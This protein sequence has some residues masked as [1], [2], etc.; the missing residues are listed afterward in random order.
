MEKQKLRSEIDEKYK[1][2]LTLI[3]KNDEDFLEDL[4]TLKT[5]MQEVD[6][7][8]DCLMKN[9][10]NLYECLNLTNELE[11]KL[12]KVYSYAH[13]H[14][15]EDTT[16]SKYQKYNGLVS[17][18]LSEYSKISG[19]IMP[20]ILKE[21]YKLLEKYYEDLP[22]LKQEYEFLLENIF[23]NKKYVLD[24][25]VEVALSKLSKAF[26]NSEEIYELLTDSDF[27]FD[28]IVDRNNKEVEI[29]NS[30]YSKYIESIDRNERKKAF[31]NLYKTYKEHINSLSK[32]LSNTVESNISISDLRGYD[33]ALSEALHSDNIDVKI[34]DNLIETVSK[35]LEPLFD[36]Y[37]HKKKLL[38]LNDFHIYDIYAPVISFL[39]K[40]YTFEEAKK[41]VIEA[42]K[43]LGEEYIEILNKAFDERWIDVYNNKGKRGGA[44]SSG[45]YLTK[46]YLLLNYEGS[47]NDV[48]TLAHELGHSMHTYFSSK[49]NPYQYAYYKIFV[50]EVASTVN[51]LL[52]ANYILKN[53]KDDDEK[54]N[55]LNRLLD[56]YKGTLFRQTMF[57]EFEKEIYESVKNN[58]IL[59][60]EVLNE[61]YFDL[62]K[63]YF[64]DSVI[65]D[66]EIKYEWSRIPHFYYF[67]YV[68]KYATSICAST[69]IA[70]EIINGN[71]EVKNKYLKFLT[72]GGSMYPVDELKTIGIDMNDSKIFENAID[73][74]KKILDEF[75]KLSSKEE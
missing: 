65:L 70:N 18:L 4:N 56:Q 41:L 53:S 33:S 44:Y 63:K 27:T 66:E 15:D 28:S 30:N 39:E 64:G 20:S 48:S 25:K 61:K 31:E 37:K 73:Y 17:N 9:A 22:K 58:E 2:D 24:E 40:S 52:L 35:N 67:F 75:I 69:Y 29:T 46:P 54:L 3:Y 11:S 6:K 34:Y 45:T 50:A 10:Q 16:N 38:K 57:A 47:L 8:K 14:Y 21:D 5:E 32:C 12:D 19:F 62:N 1:W 68:Y 72:L 71:E 59:T 13:L 36:Y 43:P 7:F 60:A 23:R 42:L 26:D 51:E 49:N 55:I 74:F